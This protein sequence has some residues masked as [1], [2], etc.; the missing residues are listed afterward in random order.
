MATYNLCHLAN[1]YQTH[2]IYDDVIINDL[3]TV[4][5][6]L[7][8]NDDITDSTL[9]SMDEFIRTNNEIYYFTS[10][11]DACDRDY[12]ILLWVFS[13]FINR[14][15]EPLFLSFLKDRTTD[16]FMGHFVGT[17]DSLSESQVQY[18]RAPSIAQENANNFKSE[19]ESCEAVACHG[20]G[21]YL[22]Q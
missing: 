8:P 9:N 17:I 2:K 5:Y 16:K 4:R 12:A 1:A 10:D 18:S 15:G 14:R 3:G 7:A 22:Y 6:R 13:G 20:T 19:F 21:Y 11:L